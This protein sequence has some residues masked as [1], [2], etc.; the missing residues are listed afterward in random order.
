MAQMQECAQSAPRFIE[1]VIGHI[2]AHMPAGGLSGFYRAAFLD[3]VT[4]DFAYAGQAAAILGQ[5]QPRDQDRM[6]AFFDLSWQRA[7]LGAL[8]RPGFVDNLQRMG[9]PALARQIAY[10]ATP[11]A[12]LVVLPAAVRKVALVAP[13]LLSPQHPPSRMVLDQA[14]VLARSGID[15]AVY[16]CQE[17]MLPDAL[18]LLGQSA[19]LP[20]LTADLPA[21][22]TA[23]QPYAAL[24]VSDSRFSLTRRWRDML[25]LIDAA[26]PDLVMLVGLHSGLIEYLYQRYPVLGLATNSVAPMVATDVWLTAQPALHTSEG[27]YWL[28]GQPASMAFYHPFRARRRHCAAALE[29]HTLGLPDQAVLMLSIGNRLPQLVQGHW[30]EQMAALLKRYPRLHWLLLGGRGELPPALR[31]VA[32]EQLHV[33]PHTAQAMEIM[34]SCDIYLNPPM[35]GGGLSVSEAMSLGLP[36]ASLANSDGGDKLGSAAAPDEAAYFARLEWWIT[37]PAARVAA[38]SRLRQ[39]FAQALDLAASGPSLLAACE[40]ARQ[41]FLQRCTAP[42]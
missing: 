27:D 36:V 14:E 18:H 12:R 33:L 19:E 10:P 16:S 34:A 4:G 35:M 13:T 3:I 22:R 41:R 1:Q 40:L 21:C 29:R 8:D 15:V 23:F 38:G 6:A 26:R 30:A 5:L 24:S 25:R 20:A 39:H 42:R 32:P 28:A 37:D 11:Q 7:L 9:V 17:A 31:G 2:Q